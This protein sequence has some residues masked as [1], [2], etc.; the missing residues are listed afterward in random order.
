M[1]PHVCWLNGWIMLNHPKNVPQTHCQQTN[2]NVGQTNYPLCSSITNKSQW[3]NSP[4]YVLVKSQFWGHNFWAASRSALPADL[5]MH[6]KIPPE[7]SRLSSATKN[8]RF[9]MIHWFIHEQ[10]NRSQN[11]QQP[12]RMFWLIRLI[13]KAGIFAP[14][15]GTATNRRTFYDMLLLLF[16][17]MIA[18]WSQIYI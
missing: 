4:Y 9:T 8:E 18:T 3:S 6:P 14:C 16:N 7:T 10:I 13:T 11:N 1:I 15:C 12:L 17:K 5:R 2:P